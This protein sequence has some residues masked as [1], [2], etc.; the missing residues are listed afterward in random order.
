MTL[1]PYD[2]RGVPRVFTFSVHQ[3]HNYPLW[4]PRG[5]LDVGLPDGA[6][7]AEYLARVEI[8]SRVVDPRLA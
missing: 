5:S 1:G 2:E 7:D 3:Q 6:S 4:K 8:L